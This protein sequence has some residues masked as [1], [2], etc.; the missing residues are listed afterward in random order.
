MFSVGL[1]LT[2]GMMHERMG[3]YGAALPDAVSTLP[4]PPTA[5][6]MPGMPGMPSAKSSLPSSMHMKTRCHL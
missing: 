6:Q 1:R 2:T 3:R 5:D 4:A